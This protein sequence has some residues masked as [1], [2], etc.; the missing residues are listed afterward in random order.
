LLLFVDVRAYADSL[1]VPASVPATITSDVPLHIPTPN[2]HTKRFLDKVKDI[3]KDVKSEAEQLKTKAEEV[4]TK[5]EEVK[6][7]A[8][9]VADKAQTAIASV[10]SE[11]KD[12]L[13]KWDFPDIEP[14]DSYTTALSPELRRGVTSDAKRERNIDQLPFWL[15]NGWIMW[16]IYIGVGVWVILIIAVPVAIYIMIKPFIDLLGEINKHWDTLKNVK[17]LVGDKL[18]EV[19]N[20]V[21][22]HLKEFWKDVIDNSIFDNMEKIQQWIVDVLTQPLE[23][24]I[25]GP[26]DF[27]TMPFGKKKKGFKRDVP[28]LETSAHVEQRS[29]WTTPIALDIPIEY[30]SK[31][32]SLLTGAGLGFSE[33]TKSTS[34]ATVTDVSTTVSH[35]VMPTPAIISEV[36]ISLLPAAN[37]NVSS[38]GLTGGASQ[39]SILPLFAVLARSLKPYKVSRAVFQ[40]DQAP[41]DPWQAYYQIRSMVMH[42]CI[43][44]DGH[45]DALAERTQKQLFCG[46]RFASTFPE[47]RQQHGCVARHEYDKALER[48]E[49]FCKGSYELVKSADASSD[50][51]SAGAR[52]RDQLCELVESFREG[53]PGYGVEECSSMKG[54]ASATTDVVS[55]ATGATVNDE[56]SPPADEAPAAI[57]GAS[58][59]PK[60]SSSA[61]DEAS[62]P[63]D[64]AS[65]PAKKTSSMADQDP[66]PTAKDASKTA[67]EMSPITG[68]SSPKTDVTT[69]QI[70]AAADANADVDAMADNMRRPEMTDAGMPEASDTESPEAAGTETDIVRPKATDT[71]SVGPQIS[72]P[73][74][75][76]AGTRPAS[77]WGDPPPPVETDLGTKILEG[78][79]GTAFPVPA[80]LEAEPTGK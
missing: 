12:A 32:M 51:N 50:S 61:A 70:K 37:S 49:E 78:D 35:T 66:T 29:P 5:A 14:I 44:V 79:D 3:G 57:E 15:F 69:D 46:L 24:F 31:F 10:A 71:G 47:L 41:N 34:P 4:K 48:V 30:S 75:D 38:V 8:E 60:D 39:L 63:T 65:S 2:H 74:D 52:S 64:E 13:F 11:V 6:T 53:K 25:G 1:I 67:D 19:K 26:I 55:T 58:S 76:T 23:K 77:K 33:I 68:V 21:E 54:S 73:K 36:S 42:H 18:E 16:C 17:D 45:D 56:A 22:K 72:S 80:S 20:D 43:T 40:R 9:S 59:R 27:K 7:K 62:A 28:L